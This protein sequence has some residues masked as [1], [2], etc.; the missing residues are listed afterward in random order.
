MPL[1]DS[2]I[3]AF[4][5]TDKRQK[6]SCGDSLFLIVEPIS[7]G[8]GKSFVGRVRF[9]PGR[10]NP[11]VDFRI[12]VYGKGTGKW[13]LKQARDEW[14]AIRAWSQENGQD[15]RQRKK[16]QQALLTQQSK[17]PTCE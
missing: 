7:K 2:E 8:G 1:T 11:V 10:A 16:R 15:P 13:S 6:K 3:R 4:P 14:N 17:L 5:V 12:G 9:P